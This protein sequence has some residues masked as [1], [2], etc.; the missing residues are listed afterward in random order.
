MIQLNELE[1]K[2][3]N[4]GNYSN[5]NYGSHTQAINIGKLTLY[6][7]YDTVVAF[8][9]PDTGTVVCENVFSRTTGKHLNWLE[10][11]KSKRV[12]YEEFKKK[13]DEI[14]EKHNLKVRS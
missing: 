1:I 11:D 12:K 14:L 7:S 9:H 2:K 6:F 4:Y 3:W 10:P 5:D 13:L 8:S